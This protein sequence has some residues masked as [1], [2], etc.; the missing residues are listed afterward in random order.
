MNLLFLI[1]LVCAVLALAIPKVF[2][3]MG[4]RR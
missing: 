1:S 3:L 2:A 4:R